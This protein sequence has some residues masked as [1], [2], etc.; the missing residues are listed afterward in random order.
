MIQDDERWI[1]RCIELAK[2][3]RAGAAPNPLVGAV[4]V[5]EGRIL[6]EGFHAR[7]GEG[8]AEVNA[9]AAVRAE[10][11]H[12]ISES[13]IYVSLEPCAHEGRTPACAARLIQER[14]KRVVVGC[15]DSF[16]E[17]AGRG[18]TMLQEAGISVTVGVL[19]EACRSLN[20]P[21]FVF[22]S[23]HRPYITLKWARSAD[24]FID[25]VR[26]KDIAAAQLSSW[27]TAM[28]VHRLR[29]ESDAILV[30]KGTYEKDAPRLDVRH[31]VGQS[32]LRLVLGHGFTPEEGFE[33]MGGVEEMLQE[34]HRRGVQRLLVEGGRAVHKSFLRKGFWDEVHEEVSSL[35][36]G[37][38]IAAPIVPSGCRSWEETL[39]GHRIVHYENSAP[40]GL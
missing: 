40:W 26:T 22:H 20:R 34:L 27:G 13:T 4:I 23:L 30:G 16:A 29:A 31:W 32:P 39:W 8:H 18:I 3:G 17:V 6:G 12:L 9:L 7:C 38:G 10:D 37:D 28:R 2:N 14:V 19:E 35:L 5:Y 15:V 33:A 21:F 24:G 1:R 25:S 36:L 11:R